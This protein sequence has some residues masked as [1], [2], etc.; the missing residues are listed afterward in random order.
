MTIMVGRKAFCL[1]L[2]FAVTLSMLLSPLGHMGSHDPAALVLSDVERHA[3]TD[4]EAD[5]HGH[6]HLDRW[7]GERHAG[8]AHGHNPADHDHPTPTLADPQRITFLRISDSWQAASP[9]S[10]DLGPNF[11]IERPPRA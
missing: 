5:D 2:A 11:G 7:P 9:P 8:H 10:R 4:A 3:A 1:A 6:S